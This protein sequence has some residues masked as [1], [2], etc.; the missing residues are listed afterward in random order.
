MSQL[1]RIE[2][3]AASSLGESLPAGVEAYRVFGSL[4]FAAVSKLEALMEP[5]VESSH[6]APPRVLVL[7][8]VQLISLDTT[9]LET[10]DGL[11]RQLSRNGGALV[12]AGPNEQPLSL[13]TRSGFLDRVGRDNVVPTLA[14]A[15][16]R[17]RAITGRATGSLA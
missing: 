17:A 2:P 9:A 15:I 8:L 5:S 1:T 4:F 3:V 7:D 6:A 10:L 16:A 14:E 11:R 13:F 12:L